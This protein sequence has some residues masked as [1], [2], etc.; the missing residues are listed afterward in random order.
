MFLG[1]NNPEVADA[2]YLSFATLVFN[3]YNTK[4]IEK[5]DFEKYVKQYY[6]WFASKLLYT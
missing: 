5:N 4:K 6:E 2:A 3:A 1:V